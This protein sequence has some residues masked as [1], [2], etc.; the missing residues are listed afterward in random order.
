MRLLLTGYSDLSAIVGSVNDGEIYRYINKPWK[1]DELKST[2][3]EAAEI[4]LRL[5]TAHT[6]EVSEKAAS[7][8]PSAK[9][10][11]GILVMDGEEDTYK[12][13]AHIANNQYPVHWAS[14]LED[15]FA[16]LSEKDIALV[17]SEIML[18]GE[19][20]SGPIKTLKQYNPNILTIT[21]TSFQDTSALIELINQGQVY[22]FLPKPIH[23]GLL[24][25]SIQ[26]A[27]QRYNLLRNTPQLLLRHKV[28]KPKTNTSIP[29]KVL[30]YLKRIRE[31]NGAAKA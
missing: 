25:K 28:E 23:E 11:P 24:A 14:G 8:P 6:N 26:A 2:V 13:V 21:L 27:L 19:D 9:D 20:V 7:S 1:A 12:T 5:D 29:N 10:S 30:G 3:I 16:I 18:N 31:R 17:V 15:A 22:R 4:A